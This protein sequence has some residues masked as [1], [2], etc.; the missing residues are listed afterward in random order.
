MWS[1]VVEEALS[2]PLGGEFG[3]KG[4]Q[5]AFQRSPGNS[6]GKG[7]EVGTSRKEQSTRCGKFQGS[8]LSVQT[9][10]V[11]GIGAGKAST[12]QAQ[13]RG[14]GGLLT[15]SSLPEPHPSQHLPHPSLGPASPLPQLP[16]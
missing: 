5:S 3:L 2:E 4:E 1:L 12:L 10:G 14:R 13:L 8:W 11:R 15:G 16:E 7:P 9:P 6:G